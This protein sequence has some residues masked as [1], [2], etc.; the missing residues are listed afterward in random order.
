M[1]NKIT[2][3]LCIS[4]AVFCAVNADYPCIEDDPYDLPYPCSGHTFTTA[5]DMNYC[6]SAGGLLLLTT[7][8]QADGTVSYRC[9]CDTSK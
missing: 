9:N 2:V 8:Q 7:V 1:F 6:C 5:G 3:F 4:V